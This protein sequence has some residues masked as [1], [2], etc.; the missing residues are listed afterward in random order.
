MGDARTEWDRM[1]GLSDEQKEGV[2]YLKEM[3]THEVSQVGLLGSIILGS[4]L[5]IPFGIAVA[6]IPLVG[7]LGAGTVAALFIPESPVFRHR[8]DQR[9]KRERREAVREQLVAKIQDAAS[10]LDDRRSR[11]LM[12]YGEDH[13]R[14]TERVK[15]LKKLAKS[16]ATQLSDVDVDRLDEATVD[17]LRLVY[18]RI[19]LWGRLEAARTDEVEAQLATIEHELDKASHAADRRSLERAKEDLV[20]ILERRSRLPAQDAAAAAQLTAMAETFED[21]YHRIQTDPTAGVSDYLT[22][23]TE[24]LNIE[25]ELQYAVEDELAELGRKRQARSVS[26]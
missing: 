10:T 26:Q 18:S 4:A 2:S 22:E 13:A 21:L 6:A 20:R 9:K 3:L 8:V 25:D 16:S 15:A 7:F 17:Y 1:S 5:S 19:V 11:E 14:M 24:R 23:A 12:R